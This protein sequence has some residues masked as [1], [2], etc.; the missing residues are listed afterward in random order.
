MYKKGENN[1]HRKCKSILPQNA[2]NTTNTE[3]ISIL[4]TD[5]PVSVQI[6]PISGTCGFHYVKFV[7]SVQVSM[8]SLSS[9]V[10]KVFVVIFQLCRLSHQN[11]VEWQLLQ[12]QGHMVTS[13]WR[14][15]FITC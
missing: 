2:H 12:V 3:P 8:D 11:F 9:T 4:A 1:V 13:I 5:I 14:E 10:T 15:V 7:L 6:R